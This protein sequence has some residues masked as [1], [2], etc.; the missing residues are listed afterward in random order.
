MSI[1]LL[2]SLI[3]LLTFLKKN[4][5]FM[6]FKKILHVAELIWYTI[7]VNLRE[8]LLEPTRIFIPWKIFRSSVELLTNCMAFSENSDGPTV[9]H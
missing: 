6:H 7:S 3:S 4:K 2:D 1:K 5:T 8:H 9:V